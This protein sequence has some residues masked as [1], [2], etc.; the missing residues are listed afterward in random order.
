MPIQGFQGVGGELQTFSTLD[1]R[2]Q[3]VL[4]M[5]SPFFMN[6]AA[7]LGRRGPTYGPITPYQRGDPFGFVPEF[8][9]FE[10]ASFDAA[11]RFGGAPLDYSFLTDALQGAVKGSTLEE[12]LGIFDERVGPA[13]QEA[14]ERDVTP[15]IDE[16][17]GAGGTFTGS[18]RA[19]ALTRAR[20]S[21]FTQQQAQGLQFAQGQQA[22]SQ[23]A[24]GMAPSVAGFA[25]QA[26]LRQ[27][28]ALGGV[29][30]AIASREQA[31][32]SS[33]MNEFLRTNPESAAALGPLFAFLG[34]DTMGGF[35]T[36]AS[37][38][39][40]TSLLTGFAPGLGQGLGQSSP[41]LFRGIGNL[42]GLG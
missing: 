23:Q 7:N 40:L 21:D 32:I 41:D 15:F 29:G 30:A 22:L 6:L 11:N 42:F 5:A 25:E 2:Q 9:P 19:G 38:G 12:S 26:P 36:E 27:A 18:E 37:P 31:E 20:L 39:L 1:P 10:Q 33:R 28:Q 17:Y 4:N 34:L 8:N 13:R 3:D 14:F 24:L 35:A 16:L